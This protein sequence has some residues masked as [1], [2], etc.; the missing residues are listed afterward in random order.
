MKILLLNGSPKK[1]GSKKPLEICVSQMLLNTLEQRF[2]N[3][4]EIIRLRAVRSAL[5]DFVNNIAGSDILIIASPLYVDAIPSH[6]LRLLDEATDI[7][8]EKALNIPVYVI[9]N[10]GF[11]E[12]EHNRNCLKIFKA[13]CLRAKLS[14]AQGLAV[15]AGGMIGEMPIDSFIWNKLSRAIDKLAENAETCRPGEDIYCIPR[16]PRFLYILLGNRGWK[17]IGKKNGV[18][19]F[20]M[21]KSV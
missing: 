6:L 16:V 7:L 15:G 2:S 14:Y 9:V 19:T 5:S 1:T 10:C 4:N 8:A 21:Y 11:F 18:T 20:Q 13:F 12:A 17:H 3:N